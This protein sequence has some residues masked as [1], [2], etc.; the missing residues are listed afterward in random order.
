VEKDAVVAYLKLLHWYYP[1]AIEENK[2]ISDYGM[3]M[4]WPRYEFILH[5]WKSNALSLVR[6]ASESRCENIMSIPFA[7]VILN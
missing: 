6:S 2:E 3:Q 1:G 5:E 4:P 7:I